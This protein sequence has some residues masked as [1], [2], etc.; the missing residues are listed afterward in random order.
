MFPLRVQPF[1]IRFAPNLPKSMY[2]KK[3]TLAAIKQPHHDD[4]VRLNANTLQDSN[5]G[6]ASLLVPV[7]GTC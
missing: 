6:L 2:V 4:L 5:R 1:H 7:R 3:M